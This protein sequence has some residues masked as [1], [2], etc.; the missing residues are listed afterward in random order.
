MQDW[1]HHEGGKFASAP[2]ISD[3]IQEREQDRHE[4]SEEINESGCSLLIV[5]REH[6]SANR[7]RGHVIVRHTVKFV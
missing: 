5:V 3:R 6:R 1:S 7:D 4:R 2:E